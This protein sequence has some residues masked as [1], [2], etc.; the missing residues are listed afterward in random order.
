MAV[1][2]TKFL[3]S[4]LVIILTQN[5]KASVILSDDS[6]HPETNSQEN[7]KLENCF[8]FA[9]LFH[10]IEFSFKNQI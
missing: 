10:F 9:V 5:S 2:L 6:K 3:V 8:F 1:L 7:V 4:T